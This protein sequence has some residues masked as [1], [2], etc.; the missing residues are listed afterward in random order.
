[1]GDMTLRIRELRRQRGWTQGALAKRAG[2]SRSYI[3][4]MESGKKVANTRRL[5]QVAAALGVTER[6]LLPSDDAEFLSRLRR[7]PPEDRA[8]I[9]RLVNH[10]Y[11]K[12][13]PDDP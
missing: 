10:F 4:E 7:L 8:E 3:A 11:A 9:D 5:A 2:I 13:P 12:L 1:M 6:D